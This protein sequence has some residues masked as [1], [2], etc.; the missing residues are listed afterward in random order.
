MSHDELNVRIDAH[1]EWLQTVGDRGSQ[2]DLDDL[3]F[4]GINLH[5]FPFEQIFLTDC[6]FL[7]FSSEKV[8]IFKK[9]RIRY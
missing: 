4:T 9:W 2:M 1:R 3:D 7:C 8:R 6:P 5:N